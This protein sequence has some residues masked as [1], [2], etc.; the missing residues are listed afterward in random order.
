MLHDN[1][2]SDNDRLLYDD[3]FWFIEVVGAVDWPRVEGVG[4]SSVPARPPPAV[5]HGRVP[6]SAA[7]PAVVVGCVVVVVPRSVG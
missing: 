7:V 5:V 4:E 2:L 6:E 3:W 1:L